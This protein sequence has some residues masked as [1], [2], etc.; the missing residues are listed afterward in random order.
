MVRT[1]PSAVRSTSATTDGVGDNCG[2]SGASGVDESGSAEAIAAAALVSMNPPVKQM[3]RAEE[4]A[5]RGSI[6]EEQRSV[7]AVAGS[8]ELS[9]TKK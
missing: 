3:T 4:A 8:E 1:A 6:S 9:G 5:R 7:G 2:G